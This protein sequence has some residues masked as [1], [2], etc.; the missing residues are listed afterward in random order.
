MTRK[1]SKRRP[2]SIMVSVNRKSL[3]SQPSTRSWSR[4]G[5]TR[6]L[7]WRRTVRRWRSWIARCSTTTRF[8]VS[9]QPT[10]LNSAWLGASEKLSYIRQA[11]Y[12]KTD[13]VFAGIDQTDFIAQR[14]WPMWFLTSRG[15]S[16]IGVI[17]FPQAG[18][19]AICRLYNV[20]IA[21]MHV[22]ACNRKS[23][24]SVPSADHHA[25]IVRPGAIDLKVRRVRQVAA[26]RLMK[27][28]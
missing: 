3:S 1:A 4:R 8:S 12:L 14:T 7:Q 22:C 13:R 17:F 16:V 28:R 26:R 5:A 10:L 9:T 2:W 20:Q 19:I 18:T 25:R 21:C 24:C 27:I 6:H 23:I 15:T 11:I